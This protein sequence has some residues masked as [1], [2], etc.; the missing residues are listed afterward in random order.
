MSQIPETVFTNARLVLPDSVIHGTITVRQGAI[1]EIAEGRSQLPG[2][3]DCQGDYLIP[4]V[5]DVHT[6]NL[7]RQVQP[8][9]NAR[10]PS[11]SAML[12]HDAQVA[13]AGVTTVL[14]ALC[15]GDLGFDSE[16]I[17]TF[18]DG[19]ADLDALA[20]TGLLK[21]DHFLHFRCEMPAPGMWELFEPVANHPLLRM[22][23]LMDHSPGVGQYRDLDRYRTM[24]R[25][26][27]M[28]MEEIERRI[29][30]LL[31]QRSRV[32]A[33]QRRML[34]EAMNGR[35]IPLAA[36]DD[37][38]EEEITENAADGIRISEFPVSMEAAKAAHAHGMAVIAGAP[39]LVRGGSHS[40][41]VAAAELIEA[42][43]VD[44]FASDYVPP[45]LIE[46]AWRAH[47]QLGVPLAKAIGMI[48]S[49]PAHML[50][51]DDRGEIKTGLRA[52]LVRI[53]PFEGTPVVREV[54]LAGARVA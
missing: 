9:A 5:I 45:A 47:H 16:R 24:R 11:R 46:A 13:A 27:G 43:V 41:N 28:T 23:S 32:R 35:G 21:V 30:S 44:V 18:H 10:W 38:N 51:L 6:D 8:R 52:D 3:I 4:G 2:A 12:S 42:G 15:L 20:G 29:E 37:W 1:A 49:G 17:Q 53:T 33:P 14:D 40:G 26:S 34:L 48:T 50:H 31:D 25:R 36:H 7:E 19:V 54:Y 22:V 39:N